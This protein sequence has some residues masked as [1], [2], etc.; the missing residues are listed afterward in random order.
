MTKNMDLGFLSPYIFLETGFSECE[1]DIMKKLKDYIKHHPQT[2]AIFKMRIKERYLAPSQSLTSV[3]AQRAMNTKVLD[4]K[5][6]VW[7]L[8]KG[9]H[10]VVHDG[11]C[12]MNITGIELD[13]WLRLGEKPID[14]RVGCPDPT[15]T[16]YASGVSFYFKSLLQV[17]SDHTCRLYIQPVQPPIWTPSLTGQWKG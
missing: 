2:L 5:E 3:D 17:L 9:A 14:L 15:G 10:G 6:F 4:R 1:T 13:V 12:W 16:A 8:D 7:N 11:I